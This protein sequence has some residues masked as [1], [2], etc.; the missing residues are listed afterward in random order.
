[1]S[2]RHITWGIQ[3]RIVQAIRARLRG[4]HAVGVVPRRTRTN[5]AQDPD[6]DVYRPNWQTH[7][8]LGAGEPDDGGGGAGQF[9]ALQPLRPGRLG[10]LGRGQTP[11][12]APDHDPIPTCG[13]GGTRHGRTENWEM[14]I[15]DLANVRTSTG[16]S[17]SMLGLPYVCIFWRLKADPAA[18][19]ESNHD[20]G[21]FVDNVIVSWDDNQRNMT[22][23]A[24]GFF[25]VLT[26]STT[27]D[28]QRAHIGDV[29]FARFG[30]TTCNGG[31]PRYPEFAV[32]AWLNDTLK[33]FDSTFN[34]LP[35]ASSITLVTQPWMIVSADS[36]SLK[37]YVDSANVI[38]ENP[39]NDNVCQGGF[40]VMPPNPPPQFTWLTAT[41]DTVEVPY[42][43]DNYMLHWE[44][45][46]SAEGAHI[47]LYFDTDSLG[48]TGTGIVGAGNRPE[49]DG[50]DSLNWNIRTLPV[51]VTYHVLARVWDLDTTLCRYTSFPIVKLASLGA[52]NDDHALGLVP[53]RFFLEQNYPNPFN[54]QTEL[55][56]GVAKAGHVTL[57][58]YNTL[59]REVAT[60]VDGERSPGSYRMAFDGRGL[61][62]GVYIYTLSTPEGTF[63]RK[64]MLMK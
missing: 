59:G 50:P 18:E 37:I 49:R 31:I 64:M 63:S 19:A 17:L 55:R 8:D 51:G 13:V 12:D 11:N 60:L 28:L 27:E 36:H 5:S 58:V 44:A 35:S 15:M 52:I 43:I 32:T 20:M 40:S 23:Q 34:G 16:D 1:M 14:Q 42:G 54:P 29:A 57:R 6:F 38:A 41:T 10:V 30:F 3:Q 25:K 45:Y 24:P 62:T 7:D 21:P 46:D 39:E 2:T 9:L 61:A 33:V 47:G 56:Y 53:T 26:D 4:E 48:C 22:C